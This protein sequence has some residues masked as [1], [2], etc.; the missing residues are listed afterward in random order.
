M[1]VLLRQCVCLC[2]ERLRVKNEE[3]VTAMADKRKL[4]AEILEIHS[5]DYQH[6]AE[7]RSLGLLCLKHHRSR[8]L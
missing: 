3:V 1:C 4:V 7:V 6:I 5:E 2:T 8:H